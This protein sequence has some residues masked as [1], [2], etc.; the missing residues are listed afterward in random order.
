MK[1]A[2]IIFLSFIFLLIPVAALAQT[3]D[4]FYV[5][6]ENEN[7]NG[8]LIKGGQI[9]EINGD[10]DGDV[11]VVGSDITIRGTIQGSLM[12]AGSNVTIDESAEIIGN[13]YLAGSN[14]TI[15]GNTTSNIYAA[16]ST[17]SI[18]DSAIIERDVYFASGSLNVN[19]N[20][21]RDLRGSA[22]MVNINS[23]IGRNVSLINVDKVDLSS[24]ATI[25]EDFTY[26]SAN[27]ATIDSSAVIKGKT[28]R[29]EPIK[30]S[31]QA[32]QG[33]RVA[34]WFLR[35]IYG[36][37]SI[38]IVALLLIWLMPNKTKVISK[39][40]S[41]R[42]GMNLLTGLVVL[43]VVPII[44]LILLFTIIGIP[45]SIILIIFY[46]LIIYVGPI[47]VGYIAGDY[48]V[49]K[50]WPKMNEKTKPVIAILL[51]TAIIYIITLIPI[52][53][54]IIGFLAIL[55]AFGAIWSERKSFDNLKA[56]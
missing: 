29:L 42:F 23:E 1:K 7:F 39:S 48:I 16:G 9:I 3:T 36:L 49:G 2:L 10:I 55:L 4:Q 38:L 51:G 11:M 14:V 54:G 46:G 56:R 22:G 37:I 34:N 19:G 32:S 17:I 15:N 33:T 47:F 35:S 21:N 12:T 52:L 8:N 5:F 13:L 44:S 50:F 30:T 25:G 20:I 6:P 43:I 18:G 31:K 26:R 41:T 27:T 28:K 24:N 53:G 40:I 45:V